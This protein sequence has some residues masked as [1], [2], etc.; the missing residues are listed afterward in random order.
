MKVLF[1][2][3]GSDASIYAIKQALYFLDKK[4]FI[5]IFYVIEEG[6]FFPQIAA[7][8]EEKFIEERKKTA[9][10]ILKKAEKIIINKGF[11]VNKSEFTTAQPA[12]AIINLINDRIYDFVILGSHGK[13]GVRNWLGSVSRKVVMKSPISTFVAKPPKEKKKFAHKVLFAVDGS[14]CSYNAIE[15]TFE[16]F[17]LSDF[18]IELLTVKAG[19]ETLPLEISLDNEWLEA[20]IEKQEELALEIL[21]KS[22][23][24]LSKYNLS[25]ANMLSLQGNAADVILNFIDENYFDLIVMG[26]HG[27]EG[28]ADF[29]IGSVSKRILDNSHLPVLIVPTKVVRTGY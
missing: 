28:V 7:P 15:K 27:R 12:Q 16:M 18:K 20:C 5:D 8:S 13:K 22:Q 2:T 25:P 29:I 9:E 3:D 11:K 24:I 1:C 10:N 26:S 6:F 19:M 23:D 17:D 21:S 4:T 14:S